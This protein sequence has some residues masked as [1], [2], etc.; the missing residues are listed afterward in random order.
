LISRRKLSVGPSWR[1]DESY[2]L[3][4]GQWKYLCRD[5]EKLGQTVDLGAA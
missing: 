5:V 1:V 2:V 4:A 3:V